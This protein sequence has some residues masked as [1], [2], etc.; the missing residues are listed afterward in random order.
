MFKV[1]LGFCHPFY[2]FFHYALRQETMKTS[3]DV[4][5]PLISTRIQGPALVAHV[6]QHIFGEF[7]FASVR[8]MLV[9]MR[10]TPSFCLQPSLLPSLVFCLI[11]HN[12]ILIKTAVSKGFASPDCSTVEAPHLVQRKC[13]LTPPGRRDKQKLLLFIG[14]VIMVSLV[15]N[16]QPAA[17]DRL[18]LHPSVLTGEC[19]I[20][21]YLHI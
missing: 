21:Q 6:N 12:V 8:C 17:S 16:G 13:I 18:F 5:F 9:V 7:G 1:N 20:I 14:H 4:N 19:L 11:T 15:M 3:Q 10:F 2:C